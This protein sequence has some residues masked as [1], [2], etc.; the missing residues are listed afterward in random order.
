MK[1]YIGADHRGYKLKEKL[2][3]FLQG[4]GYDV[5]DLGNLRYDQNDDYTDYA[6]FV[7]ETVAER[8]NDTRG[9]L[10]CGSGV[11]VEITAN[12][13]KN[14]RCGL[15]FN[16]KQAVLAKRHDD[17]NVIA[18]ASDFISAWK[19]KRI[20]KKWLETEFDGK[21]NHK[22]RLDKIRTFESRWNIFR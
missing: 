16:V 17:T 1:V 6:R 4:K 10:I 15:V 2:K 21:E 12:K 7:A 19:A 3:K 13:F 20:V 14:V 8:G 9:V 18:I 11:G 5:E 22:R